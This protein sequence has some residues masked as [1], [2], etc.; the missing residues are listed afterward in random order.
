MR[1]HYLKY[2]VDSGAGLHFTDRARSWR[3]DGAVGVAAFSTTL[4]SR[5]M[6]HYYTVIDTYPVLDFFYDA[7]MGHIP[8]VYLD[9]RFA[10]THG[11]AP[12]AYSGCYV[13]SSYPDGRIYDNYHPSNYRK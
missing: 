3:I 6:H 8:Y 10:D 7:M 2:G 9:H 4:R 11:A 12:I 13:Y 5:Q 1:A